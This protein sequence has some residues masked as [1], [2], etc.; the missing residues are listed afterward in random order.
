MV[1]HDT[2]LG[3]SLRDIISDIYLTRNTVP[4]YGFKT[5]DVIENR[6]VTREKTLLEH[7]ETKTAE[8]E[9]KLEELDAPPSLT[10]K[11]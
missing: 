9:R 2:P 8:V 1:Q 10:A 5:T 4:N 6:V 11:N 7:I 3:N